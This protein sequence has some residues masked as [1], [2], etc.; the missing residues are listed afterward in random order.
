METKTSQ[1]IRF[2]KNGLKKEALAIFK[3]FKVGFSKEEKRTISIVHECMTGKESF[4]KSIGIDVLGIESEC[5]NI[6]QEKYLSG[7]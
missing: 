5:D 2:W 3:T 7:R 4:Y 6:I 1:A